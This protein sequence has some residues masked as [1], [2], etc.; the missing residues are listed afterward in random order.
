MK[1]NIN[2]DFITEYKNDFWKGFSLTEVIYIAEGFAVGAAVIAVMF[3]A[4]N[5]PV[6]TAVYMA[7]PFAAP[8]IFRGFYKYQGY[9]RIS[10]LI[11][12]MMYTGGM[13]ELVFETEEH[14]T[15]RVFFMHREV[16]K[17]LKNKEVR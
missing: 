9:M 11:K 10:E 1:I 13:K 3:F 5:I 16:K 4:F 2:K 6:A 17:N 8:V 12:E 7:V 15:D 14:D